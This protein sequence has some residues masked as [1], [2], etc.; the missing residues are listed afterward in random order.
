M[1][2]V[3]ACIAMAA[4]AA[5]FVVP[6]V[7]SAIQLTSPTG[8]TAAL[9]NIQATNVEHAGTKK[10]TLLS[11]GFGS[12]TCEKATLTGTL[13]TNTSG[14]A[15]V[16]GEIT[17]ADFREG[18]STTAHCTSPLGDVTVTPNNTPTNP[19]HE[20]VGSLNWC[21]TAGAG[22]EFKVWGKVA[23]CTGLNPV[24]RKI[25]FVLHFKSGFSCTYGAATNDI[26]GTYTTH[27][28]AAIVTINGGEKATFN[29]VTSGS[30]FCPS[31]GE[32]FMAFTLETDPAP[33]TNPTDVYIDPV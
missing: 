13:K 2:L 29:R 32:L 23:G 31:G 18:G 3:K 27:S 24:K 21:I 1:K 17:S 9:I 4:V 28:A 11:G 8:T 30:I 7:A 6:S 25:F 12:V 19:V 16:V 5:F 20:G 22:N 33:G 14:G 15:H 26:V 10:H